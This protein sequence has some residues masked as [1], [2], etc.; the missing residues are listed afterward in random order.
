MIRDLSTRQPTQ[1]TVRAVL[2]FLNFCMI[3]TA[4]LADTA[5]DLKAR[6]QAWV[7]ALLE[8][9]LAAFDEIMHPAFRLFRTEPEDVAISKQG[10]L[11]MATGWPRSFTSAC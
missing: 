11:Q 8:S 1:Q 4:T 7:D 3:S 10:Y 9:D 6:E 2:L 5:A